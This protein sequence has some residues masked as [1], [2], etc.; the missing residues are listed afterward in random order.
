[1]KETKTIIERGKEVIRIEA[2][3]VAALEHRIDANFAKVVDAIINCNGRVVITGMGK[4]GSIARKIVATLNSTGTP[5]LFLHSSDAVHGDLGMVRKEDVVICISK[6]GDTAE[7][8]QL[9]PLFKRIGVT[10]VAMV[11]NLNSK[12][13]QSADIV[14]D[15]SVKEEACPFD[16]APTA[17]TTA[18]LALGDA[19][20][21]ALLDKRNFTAEEFAM[22]HPGGSLGKRLLLKIGELMVKGDAVPIVKQRVPVR[23]AILEMTT[24]RLGATCVV[25]NDNKLSG[26]ITDGDLRRLLQ[27]TTDISNHTAE[28]VMT[29]HPK[30]IKKDLLAALALQEMEA[31]SITQLIIVDDKHRPIGMIHLHDLVKAGLSGENP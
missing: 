1:M 26:I 22:Y 3:A 14:L 27:I 6:S 30:A 25:D 11:A 19:L 12:L 15:I 18:T 16:L 17:S 31:H 10:I 7:L 21:M 9:L 23:D 28:M 29:K 24:K 5:S 20:A 4:S 8:Q 13:S 2:E